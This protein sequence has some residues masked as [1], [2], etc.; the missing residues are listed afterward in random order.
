MLV[1]VLAVIFLVGVSAPYILQMRMTPPQTQQ[2]FMDNN[3]V[4]R[5]H[6]VI[7]NNRKIH[8]VETGD[9]ANPTMLFIH[10][11]PGGWDVFKAY[12]VDPKMLAQYRMISVDRPGFGYSDFGHAV[13]ILENVE[14]IQKMV[15][16]DLS[17]GNI[18]VVG[19]SLGGPIAAGVATAM[20][21]RVTKLVILAGALDP[22]AETKEL[23]RLLLLYPPL[24]W[25]A[26][27]ALRPSNDELW[28]Y[29]RG[30]YGLQQELQKIIADT[31]V[32]HGTADTS[33]PY[34]NVDYIKKEF[35]NARSMKIVPFEG[36]SHFIPWN[37]YDQ[38]RN[39]LLQE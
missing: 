32:V 29:K 4:Y 2:F 19:H 10:G 27:G 17:T 11:S 37:N 39:I 36:A 3:V 14:L 20:P 7:L 28:M 35:T 13:G 31:V 21:G 5:E 25:L 22:D 38:I 1:A 12:M 9:S 18:T 6:T 30:V 24:R 15:Q 34:R 16:Q 26:P 33:V 23:W 8:Y